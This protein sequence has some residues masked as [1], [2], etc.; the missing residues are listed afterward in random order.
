MTKVFVHGNPETSAIW[1]LLIEHLHQQ[2]VSD[3]VL[4]SPPGFGSAT[5][6]NWSGT[7]SEYRTWLI[8]ELES[9]G[10]VIDLVGHDWG[11]GHVFGVLA[12]R[13]EL[14]HSWA[15][16]CI[17]LLHPEYVWHDAAQ[18]WQTPEVGEVMVAGMV[19]MPDEAFVE[20]F[21]GLGMTPSMAAEVKVGINEEMARCVLA[22]YRDAAQPAMA[23]LGKKFFQQTLPKGLVL[24]AEEDH[25]AGSVQSMQEAAVLVGAKTVLFPDC[26]HWWMAQRPGLAAS[27]LISHWSNTVA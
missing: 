8:S 7:V 17:G 4:L 18:G 24:I 11:A 9:I 13:P 20:A 16:D 19:A 22:L 2:G 1:S 27:A 12:H 6:K 23:E 25:F 10:G 5:P 14:V 21:V 26:G 3:I 15:A